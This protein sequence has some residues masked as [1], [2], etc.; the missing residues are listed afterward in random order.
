MDENKKDIL[1]AAGSGCFFII[2][3][4]IGVIIL[5]LLYGLFIKGCSSVL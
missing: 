5:V 3:N 1:S 2:M 4:I